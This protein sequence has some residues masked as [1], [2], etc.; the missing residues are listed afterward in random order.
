MIERAAATIALT[1]V[2]DA[3]PYG[4]VPLDGQGRVLEFREKPAD[5]I[6]GDINAGTYVCW[7]HPP[8]RDGRAA[9]TSR[10]SGR[11]SQR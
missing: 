7:T 9:R 5:L 1:P 10:S 6:P 3:R 8:C 4:L 2:D 11:S